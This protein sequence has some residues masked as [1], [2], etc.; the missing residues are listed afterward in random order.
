VAVLKAPLVGDV[1]PGEATQTVKVPLKNNSPFT[2]SRSINSK[3]DCLNLQFIYLLA[4]LT[5]SSG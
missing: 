5:S 1:N 2:D 3:L 4:V